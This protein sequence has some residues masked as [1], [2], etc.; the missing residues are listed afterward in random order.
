MAESYDA[1]IV[2]AGHNGLVAA[3]YLAKAGKKTLV[4][5]RRDMPGGIVATEEFAPGFKASVG[6]DLCGLLHPRVIED[7][8]LKRHGLDIVKPDPA[9]F[10]PSVDGEPFAIWQDRG[11]TLQEI[12]R[13]SAADARAYPKFVELV[14]SVKGFLSYAFSK[15]APRPESKDTRDVLS[16]IGRASGRERV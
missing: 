13:H 10:L 7:L 3:A 6:P 11:R 2:G 15:P 9:V 4:L 12:E 16:Q 5:E 1:V 8:D 14:Q